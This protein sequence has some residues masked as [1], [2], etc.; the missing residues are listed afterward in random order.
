MK[1]ISDS[2]AECVI[3]RLYKFGDKTISLL[4]LTDPSGIQYWGVVN[5]FTGKSWDALNFHHGLSIFDYCC[6]EIDGLL[7]VN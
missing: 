3:V 4:K 1:I 6:K 7:T 2:G 5:E